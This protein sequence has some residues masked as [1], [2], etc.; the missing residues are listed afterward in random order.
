MKLTKKKLLKRIS[1][2]EKRVDAIDKSLEPKIGFKVTQDPKWRGDETI[3]ERKD[4]R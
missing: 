1:K 4:Q 3:C 2:L